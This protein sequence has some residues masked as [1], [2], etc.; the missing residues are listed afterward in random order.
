MADEVIK[1]LWAIKDRSAEEAGHDLD[2]LCRR[3]QERDRASRNQVV[4]LSGKRRK[5]RLPAK[6]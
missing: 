1:E 3:L 2:V 4:D 5:P 6:S